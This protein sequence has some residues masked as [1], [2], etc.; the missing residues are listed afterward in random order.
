MLRIMLIQELFSYLPPAPRHCLPV[1]LCS[2]SLLQPWTQV[3][4]GPTGVIQIDGQGQA[5]TSRAC[6]SGLRS[7][8]QGSSPQ[9][10]QLPSAATPL[11]C[12][13]SA[14]CHPSWGSHADIRRDFMP[15]LSFLDARV[16]LSCQGSFAL[17]C[18]FF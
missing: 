9:R 10:P 15:K 12:S 3:F 14:R 8:H 17:S 13:Q 4:R 16:T 5:L 18:F 7:G 2:V 1:P 11:L 6:P